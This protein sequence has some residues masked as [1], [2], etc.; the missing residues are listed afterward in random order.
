MVVSGPR[1]I[2]LRGRV[3]T[4]TLERVRGLIRLEPA[5]DEAMLF[6]NATSVHT[7]GMRLPILVARLDASF[8]VI[9]V[10][11]V[12]PRTVVPPMRRARHVLE[13]HE[14]LDLRVGDVLRLVPDEARDGDPSAG[15]RADDR[16]HDHR[17]D[18]ECDDGNGDETSH[19]RRE[20]YG[21]ASRGVRLDDPEEL[22]QRPHR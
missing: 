7:F 4:R 8:R 19:P 10:R 21:L 2:S 11:L 16:E 13:C 12:R 22:Q 6:P 20:R 14:T 5:P 9:D 1:G 3:P 15:E 17:D 18:G